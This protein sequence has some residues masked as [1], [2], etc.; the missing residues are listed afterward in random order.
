MRYI[1]L[2][3]AILCMS[4]CWT[5]TEEK[6]IDLSTVGNA[7][8]ITTTHEHRYGTEN[9]QPVDVTVDTS[10]EHKDASDSKQV[11]TSKTV[12]KTTVELPPEVKQALSALP[13]ILAKLA[14]G[15]YVGAAQSGFGAVAQWMTT[16]EG[17]GTGLGLAGL[18]G[19]GGVKL[20]KHGQKQGHA[21]AKANQPL[22]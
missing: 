7:N 8:G 14:T 3:V 11:E 6:H 4:G 18:L 2:I 1:L 22:N 20:H 17:A 9:G 12:E 5:R 15:N 21:K 19:L 16:P 13:G 10:T